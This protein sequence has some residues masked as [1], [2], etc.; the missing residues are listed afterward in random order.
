MEKF[1]QRKTQKNFAPRE[2]EVQNPIWL[3]ALSTLASVVLLLSIVLV[4][5]LLCYSSLSLAESSLL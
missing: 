1:F 5:S 2:N 3:W 4:P